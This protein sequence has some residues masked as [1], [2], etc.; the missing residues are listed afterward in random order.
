ML[1]LLEGELQCS[2]YGA[3]EPLVHTKHWYNVCRNPPFRGMTVSLPQALL[4]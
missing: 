1:Q 4:T 2:P 3:L